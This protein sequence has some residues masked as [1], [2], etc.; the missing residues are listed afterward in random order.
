[1]GMEVQL[2][3]VVFAAN[4]VSHF[5]RAR[6]NESVAALPRIAANAVTAVSLVSRI[7][8]DHRHYCRLF[9]ILSCFTRALRACCA[10]I[11]RL[12]KNR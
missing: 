8:E 1:M 4:A 2:M 6:C 7:A 5:A 11:Y 10:S 9:G 12:G 3:I